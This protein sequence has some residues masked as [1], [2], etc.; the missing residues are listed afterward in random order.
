[1]TGLKLFLTGSQA[2]ST[3]PY[4]GAVEA[5]LGT[6]PRPS[7]GKSILASWGTQALAIERHECLFRLATLFQALSPLALLKKVFLGGCVCLCE[8]NDRS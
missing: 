8:W 1:M 6:C 4:V 3:L 7:P 2:A 5:P